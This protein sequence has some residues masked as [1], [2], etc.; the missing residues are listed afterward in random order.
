MMET[1][2]NGF[3]N[4]GVWCVHLFVYM[5]ADFAPSIV[6]DQPETIQLEKPTGEG[7]ENLILSSAHVSKL[8]SLNKL[9]AIMDIFM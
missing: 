4:S 6:T 8:A 2:M 3:R 5:G 9:Q 1:A 7:I